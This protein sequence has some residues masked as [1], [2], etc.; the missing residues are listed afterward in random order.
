MYTLYTGLYL[1]GIVLCVWRVLYNTIDSGQQQSML[2]VA[3]QFPDE[4]LN[5]A[6]EVC[7]ALEESLDAL[8]FPRTGLIR[9]LVEKVSP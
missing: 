5:D 2:K 6:P 3:V 8:Q 7:W 1:V 9:V 4:L